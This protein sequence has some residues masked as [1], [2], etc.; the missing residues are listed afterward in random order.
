MI[1]VEFSTSERE[2]D[3]PLQSSRQHHARLCGAHL[4]TSSP[5]EA[6]SVG[7]PEDEDV[8]C[9]VGERRSSAS[10]VVGDMRRRREYENARDAV[11]EAGTNTEIV[12][13]SEM[14]SVGA[15]T[16]QA[17]THRPLHREPE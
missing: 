7:P 5:D 14:V 1:K 17:R 13:R 11:A 9:A 4:C 10:L 2:V 6:S 12:S 15:R 3:S 8:A 16:G